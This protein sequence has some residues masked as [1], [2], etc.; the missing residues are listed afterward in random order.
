MGVNNYAA[1]FMLQEYSRMIDAYHDLHVQKNELIK[2]YLAF[3]SLPLSIVAIFLSLFKYL[4]SSLQTSALAQALQVAAIC[5]SI[6]LFLVGTSVMM[7]MLRIRGEQYLYVQTINE[8]RGYF[9][10]EHSLPE[11]YLVLPT[12]RE[13]MTFAQ[14]EATGRPFWEAMI[15]GATNSLLSG[16]LAGEWAYHVS[17]LQ[18]HIWSTSILAFFAVAAGHV[19]FVHWWLN[20]TLKDRGIEI[21]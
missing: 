11:K 8:A 17:C 14:K 3:A 20:K 9:M 19:L 4:Q 6:L 10:T 5:L 12:T 16:F 15:V 1:Q 2:I 21:V 7:S 18:N 13:R